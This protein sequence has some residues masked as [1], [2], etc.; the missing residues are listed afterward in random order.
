V[1]DTANDSARHAW[2]KALAPLLAV[3]AGIVTLYW[4]TASSMVT[5]WWRSET[6]THAFLVPPMVVWLSWR[7]RAAL[8]TIVPRPALW[9]LAPMLLLAGIWLLGQLVA[10]NA[11]TQLVFVAMLV[12]AV[13]L[14]LGI[15]VAH[16][17]LF[18]LAFAFFAVPI[19]EFAMPV[20]MQGTA[21]FTIAA[22]RL[23]GVPVYREGLKFVIPSGSWSVVEA[24]SGV[25]YLI[26]SFMV[27]S[28]FAYLNYQSNLRRWIFVALSLVVPILANW[29]RAYMIV[30]LGHLSDNRLA[31]GVDHLVYG[32]VFFGVV[33]M[34]LF[35]IG[36]R[37]AE[38]DLPDPVPSGPDASARNANATTGLWMAAVASIVVASLPVLAKARLDTASAEPMAAPRLSLPESAAAGWQS[39]PTVPT[40]WA[41]LFMN[42]TATVTRQYAGPSG[43]QVG[44]HLLYY[45]RQR[46]ESK[47]VSSTNQVVRADD[48]V[49]NAISTDYRTIGTDAA[50]APVLA[51]ETALLGT[52]LP[53]KT[54]RD[55][56]K[57]WMV[58]WIDGRWTASDATAKWRGAVAKLSGRGDEGAAVL[59]SVV[60]TQP[61]RAEVAVKE[62]WANNRSV[63]EA[64]LTAARQA[65]R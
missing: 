61:G 9:V 49:W 48:N 59:L 33:I 63:I 40:E 2:I 65:K 17:L 58:Y 18:P 7:R 37:W 51:R 34:A 22:L 46:D 56:L 21:D 1:N 38:P 35:T 60:D 36:A 28:L 19:G 30:M 26:A 50:G 25:R 16:A 39:V 8:L 29:V 3:L 57:V 62:F 53:G 10:V 44:V 20:L 45:Q 43:A 47:V 13:P 6:F 15:Q 27:G 23:S 32:W 31:T 24:C 41:P 54:D 52:A 64:Q 55:R 5:I 11:V 4:G 12:L 14:V 42:P